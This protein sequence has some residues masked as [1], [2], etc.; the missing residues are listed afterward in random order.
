MPG[1]GINLFPG[2]DRSV[3]RVGTTDAFFFLHVCREILERR[4]AVISRSGPS[5]KDCPSG[6]AL[7]GP[8]SHLKDCQ[9]PIRILNGSATTHFGG[10]GDDPSVLEITFS[11]NSSMAIFPSI[12]LV[13]FFLNLLGESAFV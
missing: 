5:L 11:P 6:T 9:Q 4:D 8:P 3:E 12:F 1:P 10:M 2:V 7:Q 13:I